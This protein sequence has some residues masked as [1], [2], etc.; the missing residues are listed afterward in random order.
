MT[1]CDVIGRSLLVTG[2]ALD[3]L[4]RDAEKLYEGQDGEPC[5]QTLEAFQAMTTRY[6]EYG[7]NGK[8]HSEHA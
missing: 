7:S 8:T 3:L 4:Q 5:Q 1:N 6:N 2:P